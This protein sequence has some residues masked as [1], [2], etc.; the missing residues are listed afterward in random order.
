MLKE[1]NLDIK[2]LKLTGQKLQTTKHFK[3]FILNDKRL[4][5]NSAL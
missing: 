1:C 5:L 3:N 4:Q 2:T